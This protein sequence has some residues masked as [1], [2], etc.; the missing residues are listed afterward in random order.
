MEGDRSNLADL[1]KAIERNPSSAK[2]FAQ[3]GEAYR[4]MN[5]YREALLDFNQAIGLKPDY[6][7]AFAHR[8]EAH[9]L[10]DNHEDALADF[11]QAIALKPD[12]VWAIAHRGAT[13]ERVERYEEALADLNQAIQLNSTYA[14]AF[15][16]RFRTYE[17][18]REY[19]Q[20]LINFD[21]AIALDETIIKDWITERGLLLSFLQRYTEAMEY[22]KQALEHEPNYHL[23]LYCIAFTK[24]RWKGLA[25]AQTDIDQARS[26]L[27]AQLNVE[28][29]S[30]VLY[31][32]GGL[33]ALE[34]KNNEALDYLEKAIALD[35]IPRRRALHDLAWLD[36][37]SNF[38]FQRLVDEDSLKR[39][40]L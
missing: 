27:Q 38:C 15:A 2:A 7:W 1:T 29:D 23:T 26:V 21:K 36:L 13:Y 32:L 9:H 31:E 35:Y 22:Y 20:A 11:S 28:D 3:R 30:D 14:W 10:S 18:L 16:Y 12:Y 8:G 40:A 19:E 4:L 5:C 33:A 6:A 17:M 37:H 39:K 25:E 24:M 34:G